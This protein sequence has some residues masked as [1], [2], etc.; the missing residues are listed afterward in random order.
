M[1]IYKVLGI[2]YNKRIF[3]SF[4]FILFNILDDYQQQ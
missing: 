4:I 3:S 2:L 1:S